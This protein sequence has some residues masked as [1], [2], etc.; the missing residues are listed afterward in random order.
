M[1]DHNE[2]ESG[3]TLP[4]VHASCRPAQIGETVFIIHVGQ[5]C[6]HGVLLRREPDRGDCSAV[7]L[8]FLRTTPQQC[9]FDDR[10][11]DAV[12]YS[13]I[14]MRS[15]CSMKI[16]DLA[17][18]AGRYIMAQGSPAILCVV[19]TVVCY[20]GSAVSSA[21]RRRREPCHID[22]E[23]NRNWTPY[24]SFVVRALNCITT[25]LNAG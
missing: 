10:A 17:R 9:C 25:G 4:S 24:W 21:L 3:E 6:R 14:P 20:L 1:S 23:R 18:Y 2:K 8:Q 15:A 5:R 12:S 22:S 19:E 16:N 7:A 11:S 13:Y